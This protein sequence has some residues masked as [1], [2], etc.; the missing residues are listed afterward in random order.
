VAKFKSMEPAKLPIYSWGEGVADVRF[1]TPQ[2]VMPSEVAGVETSSYSPSAYDLETAV[3][4]LKLTLSDAEPGIYFA[5]NPLESTYGKW[6]I[7]LKAAGWTQIPG[8]A[9]NR[10][11]GDWQAY[12]GPG[13]QNPSNKLPQTNPWTS[14]DGF[15]KW[16]HAFYT[17]VP[18]R[19]EPIKFDFTEKTRNL[20]A[21]NGDAD[22]FGPNSLG[23]LWHINYGGSTAMRSGYDGP[24]WCKNF[25]RLSKS[26]GV[27]LGYGLPE[28][29]ADL[30]EEFY[31][32][33]GLELDMKVPEGWTEFLEYGGLRFVHNLAKLPTTA[34]LECPHA[35]KVE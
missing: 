22:L 24:K 15:N 1:F 3:A 27:A 31:T 9:L 4:A 21:E 34:Q 32:I 12:K 33:A 8:C 28:C 30:D 2:I 14:P 26:C 29:G 19:K 16:I 17:I 10:V 6:C 7:A 23:S 20:N 5:G 35:M 25:A 18:G 11:W 13:S